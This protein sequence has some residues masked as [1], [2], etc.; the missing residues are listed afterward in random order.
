MAGQDSS[1]ASA[2]RKGCYHIIRTRS[3]GTFASVAL[4]RCYRSRSAAATAKHRGLIGDR[5]RDGDHLP[6][7][8][9]ENPLLVIRCTSGCPCHT[10]PGGCN[11]GNI[12]EKPKQRKFCCEACGKFRRNAVETTDPRDEVPRIFCEPCSARF[13]LKLAFRGRQ[14]LVRRRHADDDAMRFVSELV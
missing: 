11:A 9:E 7:T 12:P 14:A 5:S 8:S 4:R 3:G 2:E 10:W 6:P 13:T 1:S